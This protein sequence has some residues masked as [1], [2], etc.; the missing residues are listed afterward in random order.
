MLNIIEEGGAWP[1]HLTHT[2]AAF[3]AKEEGEALDPLCFRCLLMMPS[4]YRLW[5]RTRLSHLEP[6]V[7]GWATEEIYAG[8]GGQGAEDAAYASAVFLEHCHLNGY[9][10]TGGAADIFKCFDQVM[11]PLIYELLKAAGMPDK[12][13]KPYI[14]FQERLKAYNAIAGGIGKPFQKPTSIPQGAP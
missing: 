7:D 9:E 2:R 3:L 10:V 12:V 11:R 8:V 5:A 1:E 13:I 14:D 4:I 6:W